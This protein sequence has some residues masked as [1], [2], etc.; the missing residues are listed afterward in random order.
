M[1]TLLELVAGVILGLTFCVGASAADWPK[2]TVSTWPRITVNTWPMLAVQQRANP[3]PKV[4]PK[5]S[6][7]VPAAPK[8]A[9]KQAATVPATIQES[10][11]CPGGQCG[12]GAFQRRLFRGR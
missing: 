3:A 4:A 10:S 2:I 8:V 1:S 7:T 5:Q 9:P 6:A 11:S 12:S